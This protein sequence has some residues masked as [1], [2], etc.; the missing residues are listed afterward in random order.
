MSENEWQTPQAI[1]TMVQEV[2]GKIELDPFSSDLANQRIQAGEYYTKETDSLRD[3]VEWRGKVYMNPPYST[4]VLRAATAKFIRG[5]RTRAI[6]EGIVLVNA[7][8]STAVF[9]QLASAAKCFCLTLGRIEFDHPTKKSSS[10]RMGQAVFYFG[11]FPKEFVRVF[12]ELG[13]IC[14]SV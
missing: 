10:N 8:T 12:G 2:M 9:H 6:R 7:D 13:A 3:E 5:W 1:I 4:K 14:F 11:D